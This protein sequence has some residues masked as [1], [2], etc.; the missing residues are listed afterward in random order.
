MRCVRRLITPVLMVLL[1][2]A[3]MACGGGSPSQ[4]AGSA[5]SGT[6][7]GST[8]TPSKGTLTAVIDGQAYTGIVAAVPRAD[9]Y[10]GVTAHNAALTLTVSFATTRPGVGTTTVADGVTSMAVVTTNGSTGA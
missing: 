5:S 3:A 9:G 4:P 10:F 6:G 8:T 1:L 7:S 2:V